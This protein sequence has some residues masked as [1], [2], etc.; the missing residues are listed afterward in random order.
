M[1]K[2]YCICYFCVNIIYKHIPIH[3]EIFQTKNFNDYNNEEY[4]NLNIFRVGLFLIFCYA[5]KR[6]VTNIEFPDTYCC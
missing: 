6:N 5:N 4:Y 2:I 3:Y 1:A